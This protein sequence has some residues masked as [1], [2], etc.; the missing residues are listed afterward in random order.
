MSDQPPDIEMVIS[1]T[2]DGVA[3]VRQMIRGILDVL[4]WSEERRSDVAIA[5]TEACTNVVLHAYPEGDGDYEV[6]AWAAPGWLR[7]AVRDFGQGIDSRMTSASA[8]LGLGLPLMLTLGDEV[9]FAS[10]E[11]GV[12]T[13]VRLLFNERATHGVA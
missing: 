5:V 13:E 7:V 12:A 8:G 10:T 11:A 1:A 6:R 2:P 4:G 9:V 3:L